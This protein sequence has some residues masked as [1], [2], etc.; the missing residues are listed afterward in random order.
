[1]NTYRLWV[2][3]ALAVEAQG[4]PLHAGSLE[5][6]DIMYM[7]KMRSYCVSQYRSRSIQNPS[8]L[9]THLRVIQI[10]VNTVDNS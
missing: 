9:P 5:P 10:Q 3:Q 4:A 1:M 7:D 2:D 8:T 6:L